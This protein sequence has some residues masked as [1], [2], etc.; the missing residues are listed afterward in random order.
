MADFL[1]RLAWD[2]AKFALLKKWFDEHLPKIK[3]LG[4]VEV[5]ESSPSHIDLGADVGCNIKTRIIHHPNVTTQTIDFAKET[6]HLV[7]R[8]SQC[9]SANPLTDRASQWFPLTVNITG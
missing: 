4:V 1:P 9:R 2:K 6:P 5:S 8:K 3:D 7:K